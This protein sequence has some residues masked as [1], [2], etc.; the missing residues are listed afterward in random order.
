MPAST[1]AQAV[2]DCSGSAARGRSTIALSA[3]SVALAA[4]G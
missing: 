3:T 1:S 2:V 4:A